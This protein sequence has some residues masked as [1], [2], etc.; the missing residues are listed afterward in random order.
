MPIHNADIAAIFEEIADLLE[1]QDANPFRVRAYR[2]AARTIG[3]YGREVAEILAGG[4]KL[5]KLPGIGADLA[6]KIEEIATTGRSRF[7]EELRAQLPPT[8]TQLL[9][10][11][12]LGPKRV[13]MLY[14]SLQVETLDQ[15]A[16][17]AEAGRIRELPGFGEKTERAILEAIRAHASQSRRYSIAV[18]TQYAQ[19]LVAHLRKGPGVR[20]A[21][22]AGSFRRAKE[23][24]GDLDILVT[25][26]S[27]PPVMTH[28]LAYD[29]IADVLS[30]GETRSSVVLK[31]GIQVDVRVVPEESFGAALH[32]FT[33]SKPHN[34]AIRKLGQ[35]RG[36]KI[37]EYGVF[38]GERRIAGETEESV[39][40]AVG[41][42]WIPPELREDRGEIE[43]ARAGRLPQLVELKALRG[44]L[45]VHSK[46]SDGRHTLR[47]LAEEA[48]RRGWQYLAITDHS[49]RLAVTH[50]LDAK[51]LMQ[52][53][54]EIDRLNET[55][56]GIRLLKGIE[57]DILEDG[58]LDLADSL[59]KELDLVVAA[60]HSHFN[61]PREQQ[62]RRI[63]RAM[64]H[65]HFTLLAHPSGREIGGRP[66]MDVDME[67]IIRHAR[68]RGCYLELNAQPERLDLTD[69]HCQL[70][71]AEGVLVSINSDAHTL[72]DFDHLR[73]GV[74]QARRGWLEAKD[75][76]NTRSL[77]ELLPIL[78]KTMG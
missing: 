1:I 40:A 68:E 35:E 66:P 57:V 70:A 8:I 58:S 44:D 54:E 32:Y 26:A 72:L 18:A 24:V 75:V 14:D 3:E 65:P 48:H 59:L 49:P 36:L 33:G 60:V 28:L 31:S 12:G 2:N 51:R 9:S 10:I 76:L 45:H 52:Q 7:L 61:L 63:L 22:V 74:G 11:P 50:G 20:Q 46:A 21:V 17:A 43:A 55:L 38:R 15:L 25:A 78:K 16:K 34:I 27:G 69:I 37:N 56:K 41:L 13:K 42:P 77:K 23:T 62:T 4:G 5:P 47:E 64:D 71:K 29:E 6:A 39:F 67:R 73:F 19:S 53:M 30:H